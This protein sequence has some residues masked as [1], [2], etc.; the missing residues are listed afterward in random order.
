MRSRSL[1]EDSSR[2]PRPAR[3]PALAQIVQIDRYIN[4]FI[5][6][7]SNFCAAADD[8]AGIPAA[9][10]AHIVGTSSPPVAREATDSASELGLVLRPPALRRDLQLTVLPARCERR[11]GVCTRELGLPGGREDRRAQ[12][13]V[14]C[15]KR[16]EPFVDI[17][18]RHRV[19]IPGNSADGDER[20][21]DP[22]VCRSA[23]AP[24]APRSW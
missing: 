18:R 17:R 20:D 14:G 9:P 10:A 5:A 16:G 21:D 19:V 15:C 8:D 24:R 13:I 6:S 12:R 1:V 22:G 3:R 11:G 2:V 4:A 23:G 7:P